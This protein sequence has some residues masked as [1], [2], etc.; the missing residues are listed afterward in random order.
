MLNVWL[1]YNSSPYTR[2]PNL[3][4]IYAFWKVSS[5]GKIYFGMEDGS[6]NSQSWNCGRMSSNTVGNMWHLQAS[7]FDLVQDLQVRVHS[8]KKEQTVWSS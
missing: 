7:N 1:V 8:M 4:H 6:L 5:K 3:E 2:L